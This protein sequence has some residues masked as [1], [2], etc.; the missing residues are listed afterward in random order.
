MPENRNS[1]ETLPLLVIGTGI[2][3]ALYLTSFYSF[4]LFHVLVEFFSVVV[5]GAIFVIAWSSRRFAANGY[6]LVIGIAHLCVGGIDLLHTIA[7]KGMG[8]FPGFDANLPTQLWIAGRYLQSASFLLAPF[9]IGRRLLSRTLLTAYLAVTSL[10][11][12]AIFAWQIFRSEEH[13]SELQSH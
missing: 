12:A 10:L 3:V 4:V 2:L 1:S 5:S 9:F 13:T 6:L 8:L 7:Y 11:L